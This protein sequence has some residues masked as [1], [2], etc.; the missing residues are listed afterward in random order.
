M[1][2][3][4]EHT[5]VAAKASFPDAAAE[6]AVENYRQRIHAS[7]HKGISSV[8][9]VAAI[10]H[11]A[12]TTLLAKQ[13][14]ALRESELPFGKANF[15]KYAKI[16]GDER[17]LPLADIL[18]PNFSLI[19]EISLLSADQLH[20]AIDSN[21]IHPTTHR[22]DIVALRKPL[23]PAG[24]GEP[25]KPTA[26][27]VDAGERYQLRM[28]ANADEK[29]CNLIGNALG[30]LREKFRLEIEPAEAAVFEKNP[31]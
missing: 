13:K 6:A 14:K 12:N 29:K 4:S 26:I 16:G 28:P 30:K 25:P 8:F 24:G 15:A 27:K 5:G 19:Y 3:Q 22:K 11:D 20:Q 7:Y 18:P 23:A 31:V 1:L 10:C 21:M 17:L 9:E 2:I